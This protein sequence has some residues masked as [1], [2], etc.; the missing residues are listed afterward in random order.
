MTTLILG[1]FKCFVKIH[2]PFN[3]L[4]IM[5]GSNGNGKSTT[6]QALLLFRKTIE[7]NCRQHEGY[8]IMERELVGAKVSL[9]EGYLLN[10]GNSSL[11]SN[12]NLGQDMLSISVEYNLRE[13][14]IQFVVDNKKANLYIDIHKM[15]TFEAPLLPILKNEFYYLNAERVGPR[16]NLP[17]QHYKFPNA[18]FQGENVAQLI[19]ETNYQ[20]E[21]DRERR[22]PKSASP[23][24]EQQ[25]N[26]WLEDMMP[27]VRIVATQSANTLTSQIQVENYFTKGDPTTA[28][29]LG[30]GISYVIPIIAT[31]LIAA[32]GS[33]M[34]V[35]NPEAHLH[36]S[37]QSK[38]GR[39]LSM[40]AQSGVNVIVETHSDHVI[41]GIQISVAKDEID[42][43]LTTINFFS[44]DQESLQPKLESITL[45]EKGDLSSWPKGFF[46]QTQ[47]DLAELFKMRKI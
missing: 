38:I 42:S 10:L 17:I 23:R 1:N 26:A 39:F 28:T 3:R 14:M 25:L 11:V 27:G 13:L 47:I 4:T 37:A 6:I 34:V 16:V 29:N 40:V 46:D 31:G 20:T 12:R 30:F 18:G 36:P 8:Y 2:I 43:N 21:I 41:N 33:Y 19:A 32:K 35:E 44:Q 5:A 45:N 15:S 22:H 7:E 24:L 9:N